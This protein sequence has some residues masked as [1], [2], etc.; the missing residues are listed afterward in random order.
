MP[1]PLPPSAISGV[2][3]LM[4][5]G[6]DVDSLLRELTDG[7]FVCTKDGGMLFCNPAF[8]TM[9]GYKANDITTKNVS[10]DLVERNLEWK[11]LVS[12][13]EQGSLIADYEMK[14]RRPDG[15]VIIG[16][17]SASNLHG[18][19][20]MPIGIVGVLRDITTR[21]G[22]ENELRDRAFR[23]D[24]INKIARIA[25]ADTDQKLRVLVNLTYELRKL[26]NFDI[27]MVCL[28]EDNSRHVEIIAPDPKNPGAA[29]TLGTVLLEGSL[30]D[31]LK[32]ARQPMIIDKDANRR[33]YTEFSV[34]DMSGISSMLAVPL[35]SRGRVL[36]ALCIGY[37]KPSEY[38]WD[39]AD[40]MQMIADQVA[41]L[42][43]NLMLVAFL[44]ARIKLQDSLVKTGLAIQKA[45][46]T[47]QIY[48]AIASSI[49]EVVP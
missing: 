15:A 13:V 19:D 30:V 48:A 40:T 45:I 12:L 16:S 26:I 21:K 17:L 6:I 36:G 32:F 23:T 33:Q 38:N 42:I 47:Q 34:V 14:F 8:A 4:T 9:L 44:Q 46:S 5:T 43:D 2:Q 11:A 3:T 37:A 28:S 41:S 24:I 1:D 22:V 18:P 27:I 20:G 10:T 35:V 25:G 39:I 7:V 29:K 49:K 31:K